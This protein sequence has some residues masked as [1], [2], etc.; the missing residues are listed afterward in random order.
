MLE[1]AI[2]TGGGGGGEGDQ[3]AQQAVVGAPTI[4]GADNSGRRKGCLRNPPEGVN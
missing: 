4:W 1:D 2:S 3:C